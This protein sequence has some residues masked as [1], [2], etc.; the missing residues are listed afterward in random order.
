VKVVEVMIG[1]AV[2]LA[3]EALQIIVFNDKI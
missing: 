2:Q 3:L 1:H